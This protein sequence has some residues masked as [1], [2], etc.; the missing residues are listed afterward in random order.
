MSIRDKALD[1]IEQSD[2][3]EL[4]DNGMLEG[5]FLEYKEKLPGETDSDKKEFLADVSS[6]ANTA[7]GH[8]I[9]GVR[10]V[11]N[12]PNELC[13]VEVDNPD[14]EI[15]RLE[16]M[17][18]DGIDPRIPGGDERGCRLDKLRDD[19]LVG[20]I[21][22]LV[23]KFPNFGSLRL[24]LRVTVLVIAKVGAAQRVIVERISLAP[25][26]RKLNWSDI[27]HERSRVSSLQL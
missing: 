24:E 10:E 22:Q 17:I 21:L 23:Q 15:Q 8:L 16:N 19:R 4:I 5:K 27:G 2:L 7:G 11:D 9:F 13:G 3:Q 1:S 26:T 20:L 14:K 18:R 6:F 12:V 25:P